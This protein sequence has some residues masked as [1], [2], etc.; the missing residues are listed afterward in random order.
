MNSLEASI[1][2]YLGIGWKIF[3]VHSVDG[4]GRC[5]CGAANCSN[6]AKHPLVPRG[7]KDASDSIAT[8]IDWLDRWPS[9]NVG[10]STGR[11][12]NVIVVDVDE[13]EDL[14]GVDALKALEA[15]H[16]KLPP[17]LSQTTG[18]MGKH[19]FFK[20]PAKV[21]RFPSSVGVV[22]PGIDIRADGGD[23]KSVV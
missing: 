19:Y 1:K 13:K 16:G 8:I 14:S 4:K 11:P 20:Y 5:T 18:G 12:S 15:T 6:V 10:L 22:A 2:G 3:P 23:R 7:F 9:M 17:T 21:E